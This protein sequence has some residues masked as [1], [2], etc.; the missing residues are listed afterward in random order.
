M[1]EICSTQSG[2]RYPAT[3]VPSNGISMAHSFATPQAKQTFPLTTQL[4][5][6]SKPNVDDEEPSKKVENLQKLLS[7]LARNKR[8]SAVALLAMLTTASSLAFPL[9]SNALDLDSMYGGAV[10][11]TTT[12][13]GWISRLT[14]TGF[15][16]AF[17]LVFLSEI[18]DKTFFVAGLL[19]MKTSKFVSFLGSIGALGVMTILAT[20]IGQIF[21]VV[22]SGLGEGLPL[23]DIAA[24]IAFAFFGLKTLKD[25]LDM[26]EGESIMDE[27]LAE[28]EETVSENTKL[29]TSTGW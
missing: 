9:V 22:P 21:H 24:C 17:S 7:K 6:R 8:A 4:W 16:Q 2:L 20:L 14:E 29:F 23:D 12:S 15:Y 10:A 11:M 18:G 5:A 27:E 25:A 1:S 26:E 28:A 13:S 3:S 19:A